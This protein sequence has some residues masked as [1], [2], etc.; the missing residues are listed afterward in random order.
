M[1][2]LIATLERDLFSAMNEAELVPMP[3]FGKAQGVGGLP[4]P[5]S[6]PT[7]WEAEN[8]I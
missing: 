4:V 1:D 7:L 2:A 6:L 5:F 8:D 3:P